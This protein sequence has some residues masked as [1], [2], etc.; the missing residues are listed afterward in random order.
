MRP[1][2]IAFVLIAAAQPLI[3]QTPAGKRGI[4]AEDYFSFELAADPH[5]SPDGSQVVYVVSR[6]DRAQNKRISS[7]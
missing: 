5:V 7:I 3:A 1:H 6:V 2:T 4:T